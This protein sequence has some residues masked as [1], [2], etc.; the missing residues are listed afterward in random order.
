MRT[1]YNTPA[2]TTINRL[3]NLPK[4][5]LEVKFLYSFLLPLKKLNLTRS[6]IPAYQVVILYPK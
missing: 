4:M 5:V 1:Y 3:L 6:I 2:T